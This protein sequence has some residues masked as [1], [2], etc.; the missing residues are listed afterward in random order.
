M[1]LTRIAIL[2]FKGVKGHAKLLS[3]VLDVTERTARRYLDQND[4]ALTKAA[5]LVLI[6]KE[7]GLTDSEILE[8]EEPALVGTTDQK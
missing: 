2:A 6:K 1:K 7:T 4:D 3:D 5:V 8:A